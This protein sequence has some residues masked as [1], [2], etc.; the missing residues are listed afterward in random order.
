MICLS[1]ISLGKLLFISYCLIIRNS[2]CNR[3]EEEQM[4]YGSVEKVLNRCN[5]IVI[6]VKT[7]I[8]WFCENAC[9]FI[10]VSS[11]NK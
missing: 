9:S 3:S 5:L 8:G 4:E 1:I 10:M 11:S 6:R 7:F 2:S